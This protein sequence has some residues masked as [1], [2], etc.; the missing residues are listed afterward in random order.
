MNCLA[1]SEFVVLQDRVL[2]ANQLQ[3][4]LS[5]AD[6]LEILLSRLAVTDHV[7]NDLG[8][9]CAQLFGDTR[10]TWYPPRPLTCYK[11]WPVVSELSQSSLYF[12]LVCHD[13]VNVRQT[14]LHWPNAKTLRVINGPA[15]IARFRPHADTEYGSELSA[16]QRI[17]QTIR[18]PDW[19]E[20]APESREDFFALPAS[21]L[22]EIRQHDA[23]DSM[24]KNLLSQQDNRFVDHENSQILD[25][26]SR[27]GKLFNWDAACVIDKNNF[28]SCIYE[29]Y[30]WLGLPDFRADLVGPFYDSYVAKLDHVAQTASR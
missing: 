13:L 29:L 9:G 6:K 19:P 28:L 23:E 16:V 17:W 8:L 30:A 27:K 22:Q 2:A 15:F 21:I 20:H 4:T 5:A 14:L 26:A 18:G 11:L 1:L 24:L 7:W 3:G 10:F 25:M 12:P